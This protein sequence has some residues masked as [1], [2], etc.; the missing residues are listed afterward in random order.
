MKNR[1]KPL[2]LIFKLLEW[3]C[4]MTFGRK[5]KLGFPSKFFLQYADKMLC[6]APKV[7]IRGS[8]STRNLLEIIYSVPGILQRQVVRKPRHFIYK[9]NEMVI[10]EKLDMCTHHTWNEAI[11]RNTFYQIPTSDIY[12]RLQW[13]CVCDYITNVLKLSSMLDSHR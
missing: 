1:W 2:L 10:L 4:G 3:Y 13:L 11:H 12:C 8:D 6:K 7:Y 9:T 5:L